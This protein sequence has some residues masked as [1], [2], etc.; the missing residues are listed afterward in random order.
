[1]PEPDD[2][3]EVPAVPT[4]EETQAVQRQS[5]ALTNR[6][7]RVAEEIAESEEMVAKA[8]EESARLRPHAAERLLDAAREARLFA[9]RE[10]EHCRRLRD[11]GE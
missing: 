5:A 10:R 6:L 1:V 11:R 9:E 7:A 8:Y 2:V 3:D 4:A